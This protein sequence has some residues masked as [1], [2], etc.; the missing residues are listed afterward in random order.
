MNFVDRRA[1]DLCAHA[2]YAALRDLVDCVSVFVSVSVSARQLTLIYGIG[3][4]SNSPSLT[5]PKCNKLR[6]CQGAKTETKPKTTTTTSTSTKTKTQN[7]TTYELLMSIY[8]YRNNQKGSQI[9]DTKNARVVSCLQGLPRSCTILN[10]QFSIR[11]LQFLS[12]CLPM[13]EIIQWLPLLYYVW[14][15]GLLAYQ[16]SL[17]ALTCLIFGRV[18]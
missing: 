3:M 17:N 14:L 16:Q 11:N 2:Q 18:R 12:I 10:S 1:R 8:F 15:E 9:Y 6:I 5:S 13:T 7:A 4:H